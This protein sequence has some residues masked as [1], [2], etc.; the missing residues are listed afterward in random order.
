M[1]VILRLLY[2]VPNLKLLYKLGRNDLHYQKTNKPKHKLLCFILYMFE[3]E[4]LRDV[5]NLDSLI[6]SFGWTGEVS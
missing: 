4:M 1:T 5:I 6:K 2:F 3:T